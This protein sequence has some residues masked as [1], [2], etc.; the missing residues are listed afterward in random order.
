MIYSKSKEETSKSSKQHD[1]GS[2]TANHSVK[3]CDANGIKA[4][5]HIMI[6]SR[7]EEGAPNLNARNT[8]QGDCW[9]WSIQIQYKRNQNR[10]LKKHWLAQ[11]QEKAQLNPVE[12]QVS[13]TLLLTSSKTLL[14]MRKRENYC[15]QTWETKSD[16]KKLYSVVV[17]S[18]FLVRALHMNHGGFQCQ[19]WRSERIADTNKR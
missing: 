18:K 10:K 14:Q 5:N 2:L 1:L 9:H 7:P 17:S 8:I 12:Q 6:L 16:I 15:K 19:T 4:M 11:S 3:L 13:A